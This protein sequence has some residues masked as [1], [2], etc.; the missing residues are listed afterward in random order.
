MLVNLSVHLSTYSSIIH[1][2]S[3]YPSIYPFTHTVNGSNYINS[4]TTSSL[5][6]YLKSSKLPSNKLKS[7]GYKQPV[8]YKVNKGITPKL[9]TFN[10]IFVMFIVTDLKILPECDY[11]PSY[12]KVMTLKPNAGVHK[13][14]EQL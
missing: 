13:V 6:Q 5:I 2:L 12:V 11:K 10:L 1:H 4:T 7:I 9:I 8:P 14:T 3:I